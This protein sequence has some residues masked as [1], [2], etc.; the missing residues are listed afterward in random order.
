M[1][2]YENTTTVRVQRDCGYERRELRE[3]YSCYQTRAE[4]YVLN[5]CQCD[6]D[7]C[8][9]ARSAMIAPVLSVIVPLFAKFL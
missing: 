8:N 5:T 4:N 1:E 7:Y 6:E 3:G 9:E 2:I